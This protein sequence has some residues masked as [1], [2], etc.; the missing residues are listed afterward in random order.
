[1]PANGQDTFKSKLIDRL[2]QISKGAPSPIGFGRA[3]EVTTAALLLVAVIPRNDPSLAISAVKSGADA[4]ALRICGASTDLLTETG[5]LTG[6]EAAIEEVSKAVGDSAIVGVIVGS[7]GSLSSADLR[8]LDGLGVDFIAAYPHLIPATFLE[9][10]HVGRLAI[11]DQQSGGLARGI[12]DLSLQSALVRINRANDSPPFMTITDV[13]GSRAA[14][15][16]IHRPIIAFPS[17]ELAT[18]DLEVLRD[19]GIEGV[20]LVGPKPD[21]DEAAVE[22]FVQQYRDVVKKLG[23]PTGRRNALTEAPPILP[24]VAASHLP[25]EDEDPDEDV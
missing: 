13:A 15:D 6:E 12:N 8:K 5:D 18:D 1:M 19:A 4:I 25:E 14:A 22:K 7:N 24:R 23:K 10:S 9:L 21:A 3:P 17:W 16:A 11:L 20:A 2:R